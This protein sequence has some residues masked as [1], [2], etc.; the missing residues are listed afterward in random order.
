MSIILLI[1]TDILIPILLIWSRRAS[2]TKVNLQSDE[3]IIANGKTHITILI[4][5]IVFQVLITLLCAH[6]I[7]GEDNSGWGET[8]IVIV[9]FVLLWSHV[10]TQCREF[11][12]TNKRIVLKTGLFSR[13]TK[14]FR[15][16]K[17]ESCVV[18]QGVMGRVF[19]YG[20][21]IIRGVGGNI[22]DEPYIDDPLTF[23]QY[24]IDR[25]V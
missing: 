14:E 25:I 5:I 21:I 18:K 9:L 23:R 15:Y 10:V 3:E 16:E 11:V 19:G 4:S 20:T 1:L 24:L 17:L 22:I 2:F 6:M 8:I 12:I 7:W 13:E